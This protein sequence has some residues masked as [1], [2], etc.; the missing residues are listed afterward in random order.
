MKHHEHHHEHDAAEATAT[1]PTETA[2]LPEAAPAQVVELADGETFEV[3][4]APVAKR[5]GDDT[6]RMIAYIGSIPGR[7]Q[8]YGGF[9]K[10][11]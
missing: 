5:I 6:V 9:R 11:S 8:E 10:N 7:A 3:R 1:F 4:I 2:G